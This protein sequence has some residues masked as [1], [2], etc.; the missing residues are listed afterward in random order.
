MSTKTLNFLKNSAAAIETTSIAVKTAE[1]KEKN[2]EKRN[3]KIPK[4][5][6]YEDGLWKVLQNE[7]TDEIIKLERIS[8][9][10][11]VLALTRTEDSGGWG[12]LLQWPDPDGFKHLW[13]MPQALL[14]QPGSAWLTYMQ[15]NGFQVS[16]DGISFVKNYLSTVG[17]FTQKRARL[18]LKTGWSE[19]AKTFALP[20]MNIGADQEELV[21]MQQTPGTAKLY[22][23]SGTLEEWKTEVAT[24]SVRNT[25]LSFMMCAALTG[26]MLYLVGGENGGYHILGESSKG[27]STALRMA[28]SIYGD[29]AGHFKSWRT[30]DNAAESLAIFSNDGCLILD[31]IGEAPAR[32]CSDMAYML[33][34]G[35]GKA[36][37]GRDGQARAISTWRTVFLSS[38]EITLT[39]KL[40]EVEKKVQAGQS[41]RVVEILA[42]A[43]KGFG[44][45][46]DCQG[47]SPSDFAI[48]IKEVSSKFYGTAGPAFIE[49]LIKRENIAKEVKDICAKFSSEVCEKNA[50]GQVLRVAQKF[51]LCLA[52]GKIAVENGIFPHTTEDIEYSVKKCFESWLEVRGGQ[53]AGEDNDIVKTLKSFIELHGQSRFQ[54]LVPRTDSE[55]NVIEQ[56][57]HNRCGFRNPETSEYFVLEEAWKSEIFK[58]LNPKRAAKVLQSQGFLGC[59]EGDRLKT[60]K[61]FPGLGVVRC[62]IIKINEEETSRAKN[63]IDENNELVNK[64]LVQGELIDGI[65]AEEFYA[66][67]INGAL[68]TDEI[69]DR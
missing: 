51:G 54:N 42:D 16:Q 59:G 36:R 25:R 1:T 39:Q 69:H 46:D 44:V 38:G 40:A 30:T 7:E 55:G 17:D 32:A 21:V 50:D 11:E 27:K 9:P 6:R 47:M 66:E 5:K 28:A 43:G 41:V 24:K 31:E 52:A 26:P 4:I 68:V 19:D 56:I 58:S 2:K 61:S 18:A 8:S 63:K 22:K 37:A 34:N 33:A 3:N 48:K 62:Y 12:A 65:P 45:F 10:L 35:I 13:A 23:S 60:K 67:I 57:C 53:G 20:H 49:A 15:E 29:Q 64:L 14:N